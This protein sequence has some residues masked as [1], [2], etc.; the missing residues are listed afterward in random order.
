M[1]QNAARFSKWVSIVST[2]MQQ[3]MTTLVYVQRIQIDR[4]NYAA[5][6]KNI[7]GHQKSGLFNIKNLSQYLPL[8]NSLGIKE[9]SKGST[10]QQLHSG[11]GL[12]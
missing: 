10:F 8:S 1:S 7:V 2:N 9:F 6:L 12:V 5:F 11:T 4:Q 3:N